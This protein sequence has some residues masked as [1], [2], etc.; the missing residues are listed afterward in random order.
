MSATPLTALITGITG[1]DGSYLA[2]FLLEK[3]YTVHGLV[4]RA[5]MFNRS[6]IEHLRQDPNIYGQRLFLHYADLHD[7]T[8]LRRLIGKIRPDELYHLA[9]QSHVGLSFE[10]P[11]STC[12]EVAR[13]TLSLLEICRDQDYAIRIYHASSSE[14]FGKPGECEVPQSETTAF[15]PQSPYGCAKAFSTDLCRIY[16]EAYGLFVCSGIA[17]NHESPRR[18]ENFVTRKI[19][20]A[21]AR[22][23]AG[24][25]DC[26]LLG[27]LSTSRDWGLAGEYVVAMWKMLQQ[28]EPRDYVLATGLATSVRDFVKASFL[29][30]GIELVFTGERD[31]E[32]GTDVKSGHTLVA[33]DPKFY[34]PADPQ[35]L[36]GNPRLANTTLGWSA[37]TKAE[38]LAILM[39]QFDWRQILESQDAG[40][41]P[42]PFESH[43]SPPL[44]F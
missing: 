38:Q 3:G 35:R 37:E 22:I 39:T 25:Q 23:K 20:V 24:L 36:I 14:V 40:R 29:A 13:G 44:L 6:R 42:V 32:V 41:R 30:V 5:S 27:A 15:R 34:R 1:Q 2:E 17:Y 16:R 8:T 12:D 18:G 43:S 33:V 26:L 31:C 4:R 10:I 11:E 9:G 28:A 21:T 19:S 7:V